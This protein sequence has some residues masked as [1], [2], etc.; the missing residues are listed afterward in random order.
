MPRRKP[1]AQNFVIQQEFITL[2]QLLKAIGYVDLG[3]FVK[4][5]LAE[6]LF[7][8]NGEAEARRGKKLRLGDEIQL[9]D[10]SII[11]IA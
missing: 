10:G 11:R 4:V 3:G 8:V 9:P 1:D 6:Q 5:I 7:L 2:G